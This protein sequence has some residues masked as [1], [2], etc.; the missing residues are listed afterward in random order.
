MDMGFFL[1]ALINI[2]EFAGKPR[3]VQLMKGATRFCL[4]E[5]IIN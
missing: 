5:Y 1:C 3:D 2:L 4:F